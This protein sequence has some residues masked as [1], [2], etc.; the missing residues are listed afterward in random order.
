MNEP[1]KYITTGD[2]AIRWSARPQH[3]SKAVYRSHNLNPTDPR[4]A[5][6]EDRKQGRTRM[7][8]IERL[9]TLDAWWLAIHPKLVTLATEAL[10][11]FGTETPAEEHKEEEITMGDIFKGDPVSQLTEDPLTPL[12]KA[13]RITLAPAT[14]FPALKGTHI[15]A[16]VHRGINKDDPSYRTGDAEK[17]FIPLDDWNHIKKHFGQ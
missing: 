11:T 10:K 13:I 9:P 14:E 7:W 12:T 1:Q 2:L 6:K 16:I 17:Y 3:V 4:R 5:P 15:L 8:K